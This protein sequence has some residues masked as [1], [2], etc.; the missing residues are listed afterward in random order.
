MDTRGLRQQLIPEGFLK[1][2]KI[3]K[4]SK[5]DFH[6]NMGSPTWKPLPNGERAK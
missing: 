1:K 5:V 6:E 4:Q 2:K 3:L